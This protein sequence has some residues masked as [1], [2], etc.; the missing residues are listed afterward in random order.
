MMQGIDAGQTIFGGPDVVTHGFKKVAQKFSE[1]WV[2][3]HDENL[4]SYI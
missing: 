4:V 1:G 3:V 2:V